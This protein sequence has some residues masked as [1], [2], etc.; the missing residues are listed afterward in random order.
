MLLFMNIYQAYTLSKIFYKSS[1]I[2]CCFSI[3]KTTQP[4]V[5]SYIDYKK[6]II[7]C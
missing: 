4:L 6:G 1:I 3:Y 5:L 2:F 7:N